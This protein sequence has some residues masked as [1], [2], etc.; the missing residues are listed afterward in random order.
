MSRS[1][2]ISPACSFCGKQEPDTEI[3]LSAAQFKIC[4]LCVISF[5]AALDDPECLAAL[6]E[7][8]SPGHRQEACSLCRRRTD[9][10]LFLFSGRM[11]NVCDSCVR[12]CAEFVNTSSRTSAQWRQL[13]S[14]TA[15]SIR[16]EYTSCSYT[17]LNIALA[18]RESFSRNWRGRLTAALIY[19]GAREVNYL[20]GGETAKT[21][22]WYLFVKWKNEG[23]GETLI[24]SE[25][26]PRLLDEMRKE[27]ILC[28]KTVWY[29]V[30]AITH[31]PPSPKG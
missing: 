25:P 22:A 24:R 21:I 30:D 18:A 23:S 8:E 10:A 5:E 28:G 14:G 16:D 3:V 26:I 11:C 20:F 27:G 17:R 13:L 31:K 9:Q 15:Q 2:C 7:K 4:A 19:A 6:E 1:D 12:L 29:S